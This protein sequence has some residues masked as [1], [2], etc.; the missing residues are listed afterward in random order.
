MFE[1]VSRLDRST[2]KLNFRVRFR[3]FKEPNRLSG[4][5]FGR[6]KNR[7]NNARRCFL[8]PRLATNLSLGT[9]PKYTDPVRDGQDRFQKFSKIFFGDLGLLT[10]V[11]GLKNS[12]RVFFNR[13][14]RCSLCQVGNPRP[15]RISTY[16]SQ[17]SRD[18]LQHFVHQTIVVRSIVAFNHYPQQRLRS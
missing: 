10:R 2:Q 13:R 12:Q 3:I 14:T 11:Q 18:R 8:P 1:L 4:L 9:S 17:R 6:Q 7:L 16:H 15:S 5:K